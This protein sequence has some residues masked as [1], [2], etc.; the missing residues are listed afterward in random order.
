MGKNPS[1]FRGGD[2]PVECVSWNDAQD[3]CQR[4]TAKTKRKYS[5]PSEAQ[6]EYACRA[7][8]TTPFYFGGTIGSNVANY[9]SSCIYGDG[10]KGKHLQKTT[11]V[12]S[13]DGLNSFGLYDM[14]GNVWEWCEDTWHDN[15]SGAPSDGSA[16]IA[17]NL[18]RHILRG[19]SWDRYPLD[20]RSAT[21]Y[22]S[23]ANFQHKEIGFRVVCAPARTV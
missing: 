15:Y 7:G 4:L 22:K 10:A 19:G 1:Q 23:L 17:G 9:N 2:L 6:W 13:F 14:C 16:W 21:R 18:N 5:L 3:F 8:T 12:G 11:P 20:C